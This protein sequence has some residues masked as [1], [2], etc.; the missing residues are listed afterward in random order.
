MTEL[1]SY[2]VPCHKRETDLRRTLPSVIVAANA[3]PPVEIVIVDYGH[4]T[5]LT[6]VVWDHLGQC[7]AQVSMRVVR[8][9]QL[10]FHMAHARNIGLRAALGR[11]VVLFLAD[12]LLGPGFFP[13]V[14]ER[15]RDRVDALLYWQ[16]TFAGHTDA[17]RAVGGFDERFEFYGPEGKELLDR[18]RRNGGVVEAFPRRRLIDQYPTPDVEKVR[19]YREPLSKCAMHARGMAI[20]Q[21][22]QARGVRIANEGQAWGHA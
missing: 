9:E 7:G 11:Y 12:Q 2:T 13:Y 10:Y 1:I 15:L 22:N 4:P 5:P 17:I 3:A 19:H 8:S 18:W 6:S 20:W 21:D 16:E 14:R